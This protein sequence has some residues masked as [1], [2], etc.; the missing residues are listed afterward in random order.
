MGLPRV[1]SMARAIPDITIAKCLLSVLISGEHFLV[2]MKDLG[3]AQKASFT[4]EQGS[5]RSS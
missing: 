5:G 3:M 1:V 2:A 4:D